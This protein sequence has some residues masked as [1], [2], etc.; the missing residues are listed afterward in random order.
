MRPSVKTPTVVLAAALTLSACNLLDV[1]NPNNLVESSIEQ[2]SAAS[3]VVNGAQ[4]LVA[5]GISYVWSPYSVATD[6]LFWIGSRDAWLSLDQGFVADPANEFTDAAYPYVAQARW[7]ADRAVQIL[8]EHTAEDASFGG[9]LARAHLWAGIIYMVVGEVQEDFTISDKRESGPAV[10]PANM[11]TM[12]E[13]AISHFDAAINGAADGDVK[14]QAMMVRARAKQSLAI[15][16]K[17]KPLNTAS[18]L[19]QAA[20]A[21]ADALS[22]IGMAGGVTADWNFNFQ[23]SASTIFNETAFEVNSRKEHQVDPSLVTIN[24]DNDIDD[25]AILD[26]ID[27]IKDPAFLKRLELFKADAFNSQGSRYSPLTI[28][29]TRL[30]HLIA[31]ENQLASGNEAGFATHINHVR[32]MDG[33]T[34]YS[35]QIPA[36]DMLQHTRR[37]NTWIMGL[38]LSDMYRFGIQ[39]PLWEPV[40]DAIKAPGTLLPITL[41][42]VR[43]NCNLNGLGC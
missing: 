21:E 36:M 16:H 37:V 31:A 25:I 19:V 2:T 18:P 1:N 27:G 5:Q 32:A 29:S 33:L 38:R 20:D 22:A 28:A 7:M 6:E 15:W 17:I 39:A 14:L 13:T 42:E 41:V 26:P 11:H 3:A 12:L 35:G 40:S 23:F 30:M 34:P 9:E 8:E 43:A 24:L 10:G 4:A